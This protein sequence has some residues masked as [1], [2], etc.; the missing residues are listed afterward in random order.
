[1]VV[2]T[3]RRHRLSRTLYEKIMKVIETKYNGYK[4][5]SRLEAKWALFF[6]EVGI[7]YQYEPEAFSINGINYLPDFYFP[8]EDYYVEIKA[9]EPPLEEFEKILAFAWHKP[10][11][12][13][14]GEPYAVFDKWNHG[15]SLEY[16]IKSFISRPISDE[17]TLELEEHPQ[18]G[19]PM[20]FV[21]C[22]ACEKVGLESRCIHFEK[23]KEQDMLNYGAS[24]GICCT[25]KSGIAYYLDS[26]Y[27]KVREHRFW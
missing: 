16:V 1:M 11:I 20:V 26:A 7:K 8:V 13:V 6:D 15:Q 3:L 2:E 23:Y 17:N 24:F 4:F 27:Q 10:I 22:R 12:L 19:E 18:W 25:G 9:Q 21:R 5:R 14:V